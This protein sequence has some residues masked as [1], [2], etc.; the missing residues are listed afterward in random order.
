M[1]PPP[2]PVMDATRRAFLGLKNLRKAPKA[3]LPAVVPPSANILQVPRSRRE[4]LKGMARGIGA[5]IMPRLPLE[6]LSRLPL[7]AEAAKQFVSPLS[8]GLPNVR[9]ALDMMNEAYGSPVTRNVENGK[10]LTP[11]EMDFQDPEKIFDHFVD[12]YHQSD[13]GPGYRDAPGGK[14]HDWPFPK[15]EAALAKLSGDDMDELFWKFSGNPRTW[16]DHGRT[17]IATEYDL[18]VGE[19]PKNLRE[20]LTPE[21]LEAIERLR[22]SY[23]DDF[24]RDIEEGADEQIGFLSPGMPNKT[25]DDQMIINDQ[26]DKVT[27]YA[28][29]EGL[30]LDDYSYS[31]KG[32]FVGPGYVHH[33]TAP[34]ASPRDLSRF[35]NMRVTG[36]KPTGDPMG[37]DVNDPKNLRRSPDDLMD[38]YNQS[39][40]GKPQYKSTWVP[41]PSVETPPRQD[42]A[43]PI[44]TPPR[45][46]LVPPYT[47]PT[48]TPLDKLKPSMKRTPLQL[49]N[50]YANA[51]RDRTHR[52]GKQIP[53]EAY[54]SVDESMR[55]GGVHPETAKDIAT[56]AYDAVDTELR[57]AD[58]QENTLRN[59][60]RDDF[61]P[62]IKRLFK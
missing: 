7:P 21:D 59:L 15:A 9:F 32:M 22:Y 23:I 35:K 24:Q 27:E 14:Y 20:K 16:E 41:T 29:K 31:N 61:V 11:D 37:Y 51:L 4:V 49:L 18:T 26:I 17:Y 56:T 12:A 57:D 46:D 36:E 34:E 44:E 1:P 55:E 33:T 54:G 60:A 2:K 38:R 25:L 28:E 10:Y 53:T 3:N 47:P 48:E 50:Y 58:I 40:E 42:V 8:A 13:P 30:D 62:W 52:L 19:L 43:P 6:I 5:K 39:L 45:Q